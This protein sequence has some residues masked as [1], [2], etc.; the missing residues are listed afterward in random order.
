MDFDEPRAGR[1]R[2]E[3][4]SAPGRAMTGSARVGAVALS[5]KHGRSSSLP[6]RVFPSCV[7]YC[8]RARYGSLGRS[9]LK[10]PAAA[11]A[12]L[13]LGVP[14]L[15]RSQ[16]KCLMQ[17]QL[18]KQSAISIHMCFPHTC[19]VSTMHSDHIGEFGCKS[20]ANHNLASLPHFEM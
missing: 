2:G 16:G 17:P 11:F 13:A 12:A 4:G 1:S 10:G 20:T 14:R 3:T 18:H 7:E 9:K 19:C 8:P 5:A 15:L 6:Q